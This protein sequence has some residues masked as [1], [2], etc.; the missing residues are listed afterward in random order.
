[1]PTL[2]QHMK[3]TPHK[4]TRAEDNQETSKAR[5]CDVEEPVRRDKPERVR[6][7]RTCARRRP[8][9]RTT[10]KD[11]HVETSKTGMLM[12]QKDPYAESSGSSC[13]TEKPVCGDV[14]NESAHNTDELLRSDAECIVSQ[15]GFGRRLLYIDVGT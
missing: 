11:S 2:V 14:W 3:T 4:T 6:R 12:T 8:G 15:R 7:R 9:A 10:K 13:D 5:A 1:M